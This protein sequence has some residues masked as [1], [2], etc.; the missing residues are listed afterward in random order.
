MGS[1]SIP[2]SSAFYSIMFLI[3]PRG[4]VMNHCSQFGQAAHKRD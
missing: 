4:G 3:R 1:K 2:H